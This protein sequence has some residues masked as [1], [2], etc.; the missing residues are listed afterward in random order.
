MSSDRDT[1]RSVKIRRRGRHAA[2]S[3]VDKIAGKATVA[4]PAVAIAGSVLIGAQ[5][6]ASAAT[7]GAAGVSAP[8][9]GETAVQTAHAASAAHSTRTAKTAHDAR[10]YEV[11]SG[12]TLSRISR[13]LY[14]VTNDWHWLYEQNTSII[15]DPNLIYPG[16]VLDV[17]SGAPRAAS[18]R[19]VPRHASSSDGDGSGVSLSADVTSHGASVSAHASTGGYSGSLSGTLGCSGLEQLWEAAGGSPSEARTAAGIAMAESGGNQYAVS[20]TDDYGYWQINRSAHGPMATFDPIGNAR[21]AIS[22]SSGGTN[23]NPWTTYRSGAYYG[24]C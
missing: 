15:S 20:P 5:G 22:I 23:W 3:Q 2:P 6:T 8:D 9:F 1:R 24:K 7:T 10:Q 17:P 4:A 19:Y 11:K 18:T 14:G 21:A 16:Q 12:D 13:N